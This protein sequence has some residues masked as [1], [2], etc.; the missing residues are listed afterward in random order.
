MDTQSISLHRE[1]G[2]LS[3]YGWTGHDRPL[4]SQ[5]S[6][7]IIL[8]GL[9]VVPYITRMDETSLSLYRAKIHVSILIL[10]TLKST[11]SIEYL[12]IEKLGNISV[13]ELRQMSI[14]DLWRIRQMAMFHIQL[15]KPQ[16]HV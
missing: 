12:V 4:Y 2:W 5:S 13:C 7:E 6:L 8:V 11:L 9:R 3:A 16:C 14:T 15:M 1:D 10:R